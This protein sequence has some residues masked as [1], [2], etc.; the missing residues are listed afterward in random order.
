M[1]VRNNY[2]SVVNS[3]VHTH[4]FYLLKEAAANRAR[5]VH[6]RGLANR[7]PNPPTPPPRLQTNE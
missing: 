6:T 3:H 7:D 2:I 1:E 4:I 5:L